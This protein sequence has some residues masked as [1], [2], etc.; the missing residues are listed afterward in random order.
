MRWQSIRDHS[1]RAEGNG[2]DFPRLSPGVEFFSIEAKVDTA[3]ITGLNDNFFLAPDDALIAR[4]QQ[5]GRGRLA[6][7]GDQDPG[8]FAGLDDD[9]KLVRSRGGGGGGTGSWRNSF[10]RTGATIFV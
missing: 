5:F 3:G 2:F 10:W 8:F 6:V 7:G 9:G 1:A 4:R